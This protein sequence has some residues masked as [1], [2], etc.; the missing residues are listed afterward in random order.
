MTRS[1][2][3]GGSDSKDRLPGIDH[4]IYRKDGIITGAGG[5]D[6]IGAG[7]VFGGKDADHPRRGTHGAKV[8]LCDLGMGAGG[9]TRL[10]VQQPRRA[11]QIIDIDRLAGNVF[12][13]AVMG[14]ALKFSHDAPFLPDRG[15]PRQ[16]RIST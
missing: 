7:N 4:L 3:A 15:R 2:Q 9:K 5:T 8:Q 10:H 16:D 11:R 12:V 6:I 13:G 1:G 14:D